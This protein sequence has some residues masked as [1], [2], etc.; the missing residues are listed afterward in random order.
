MRL[1]LSLHVSRF[2]VIKELAL[3]DRLTGVGDGKKAVKTNN[4]TTLV[5]LI[6][7]AASKDMKMAG[8]MICKSLHSMVGLSS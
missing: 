3:A 5:Q 4:F 7:A 1:C 6:S 2:V 8:P